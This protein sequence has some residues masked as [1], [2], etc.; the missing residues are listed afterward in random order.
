M[1]RFGASPALAR[2]WRRRRGET[3]VNTVGDSTPPVGH[4]YEGHRDE[5][6]LPMY[7]VYDSYRCVCARGGEEAHGS[8]EDPVGIRV[9]G[10]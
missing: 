5:P 1:T 7:Y 10:G 8:R 3:Y 2:A 9:K 4:E 6:L